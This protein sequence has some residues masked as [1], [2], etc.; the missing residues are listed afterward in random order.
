MTWMDV[1]LLLRSEDQI[2]NL[3]ARYQ[4]VKEFIAC[5]GFVEEGAR[6]PEIAAFQN[7][8]S[9]LPSPMT[10]EQFHRN[11]YSS[12]IQKVDTCSDLSVVRT[13]TDIFRNSMENLYGPAAQEY[14]QKL[15]FKPSTQKLLELMPDLFLRPPQLAWGTACLLNGK[16]WLSLRVGAE[17]DLDALPPDIQEALSFLCE[18]IAAIV[19]SKWA[20]FHLSDIPKDLPLPQAT[21]QPENYA[22]NP[23]C[24][25]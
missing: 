9:G 4:V 15:K 7:I 20:E 11:M 13:C 14:R 10:A 16:I 2:L 6:C 23:C 3:I 22:W 8:V 17:G 25:L 19:E 5:K 18:R 24:I 1:P 21:D 12:M